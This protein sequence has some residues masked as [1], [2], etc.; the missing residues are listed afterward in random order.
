MRRAVLEAGSRLVGRGLIAAPDLLAHASCGEMC[1]L[2]ADGTGPSGEELALRAEVRASARSGDVPA[3][4]GPPPQV[5]PAPD[6]LA[7]A[8]ARMMGATEAFLAALFED[9]ERESDARTVRGLAASPG[10]VEG[11]ARVL[12]DPAEIDRIQDREVLVT[13]S[14][15]EAFNLILSKLGGM[16][17]DSGGLL[18]HAAI[19]ARE[20][21]IPCVVGT[22]VATGTIADGVRVRIDGE[23]GEV[24]IL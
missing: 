2:L 5:P 24:S 4:L 18:S 10:T 8:V 17:T 9:S 3:M 1:S 21:G 13:T 20:F 12:H 23:K 16:V 19:L 14:T 22:R 15:S 7:P 11:T 6:A